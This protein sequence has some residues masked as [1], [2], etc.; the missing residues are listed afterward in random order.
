MEQHCLRWNSTAFDGA[1]ALYFGFE[2]R[3]ASSVTTNSCR[4]GG[5]NPTQRDTACIT[6]FLQPISG[7]KVGSG[8]MLLKKSFCTCD[9]NFFST[10]MRTEGNNR[11]SLKLQPSIVAALSVQLRDIP[12]LAPDSQLLTIEADDEQANG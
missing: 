3:M 9:Q 2:N 8:S 6:G 7:R 1:D 5:R 12:A 10:R 4:K 11:N